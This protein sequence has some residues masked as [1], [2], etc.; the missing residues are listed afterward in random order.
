MEELAINGIYYISENA[1]QDFYG[2]DDDLWSNLIENYINKFSHLEGTIS[3]T[4]DFDRIIKFCKKN[5]KQAI[6]HATL[7]LSQSEEKSDDYYVVEALL[8]M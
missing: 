5:I 7:W 3:N 4:A 6:V 1:D 8:N 2:I